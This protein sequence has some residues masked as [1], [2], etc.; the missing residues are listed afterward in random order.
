MATIHR[1]KGRKTWSVQ[2][3]W[4]RD[5]PYT[6]STGLQDETLARR[7][8]DEVAETIRL[9][10]AGSIGPIP[11]DADVAT[12]IFS[13]GRMNQKP[14]RSK[15]RESVPR[16]ADLVDAWLQTLRLQV[17]AGQRK[18]STYASDY[19][20]LTKFK[21]YVGNA[22]VSELPNLM[23]V[24][25]EDGLHRISRKGVSPTTVRLELLA[26]QK[27]AKKYVRKQYPSD[28]LILA[29][30]SFADVAQAEPKPEFFTKDEIT[31]MYEEAPG[32]VRL[33]ILLG[34]NCGYGQTD[35]STL[36]HDHI[37]EDE[38]GVL[39]ITR[40]REKTRKRKI[41]Q[42][43]RLWPRTARLL[44]LY[45]TNSDEHELALI[46]AKG[47]P[48]LTKTIKEDGRPHTVDSIKLAFN[49]VR[50]ACKI[51][52]KRGFYTLRKTGANAIE[53]QYQE[54]PHLSDL[55]L[56]HS[57]K[58]MK[59]HYVDRHFDLMEQATEW[60]GKHFGQYD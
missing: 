33:Y 35:I 6:K 39:T 26:I 1:A 54:H 40:Y 56:A 49:R 58:S 21:D 41:V 44:K 24:F 15:K 10:K 30:E 31:A 4:D 25:K 53:K 34:L 28:G 9:L 20:R 32:K 43:H 45:M 5:A 55:Y 14:D 57:D 37:T 60:L 19:S 47:N 22:E 38:N 18:Q 8:A 48:L 23:E 51:N 7:K 2:F 52:G 11:D 16:I 27:F 29:L 17:D 42:S 59:V 50:R 12:W 46:G 36:R 3:R 13:G